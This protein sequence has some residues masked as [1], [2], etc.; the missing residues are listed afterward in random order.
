[1]NSKFMS[2]PQVCCLSCWS[3]W[4]NC[5]T[6]SIFSKQNL[7]TSYSFIVTLLMKWPSH[8][9]GR[10]SC[11]PGWGLIA[12]CSD[13]VMEG[14]VGV[15]GLI[16]TWVPF[17]IFNPIVSGHSHS[18]STSGLISANCQGSAAG[19]SLV[20]RHRRSPWRRLLPRVGSWPKWVLWL[21]RDE[22]SYKRKECSETWKRKEKVNK[23]GFKW[24]SDVHLNLFQLC[25][26]CLMHLNFQV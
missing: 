5:R 2:C 16:E 26:E 9:E 8:M 14:K 4:K 11:Y 3:L 23:I 19:I 15:I 12:L 24:K 25:L 21:L 17:L 6:L 22:L 1:M 18:R 20:C 13:Q 10:W 7:S